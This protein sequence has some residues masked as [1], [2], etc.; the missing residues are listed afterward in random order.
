MTGDD[1]NL[2]KPSRVLHRV[3]RVTTHPVA[4]T[5][6]GLAVFAA[7]VI[8]VASGFNRDFQTAFA[9]VC[10]GVTVTMLFVVQHT[11]RR[12][13]IATQVKLDELVRALPQ[14]DNRIV[15]IE[16]AST[17]ELRDFEARQQQ[18]HDSVRRSPPEPTGSPAI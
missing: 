2:S 15:H 8:V 10:A 18:I 3:D 11:Q 4:S 9:T 17:E 13:Q 12:A 16:A 1:S 6:I 14:A 5:A 7:F